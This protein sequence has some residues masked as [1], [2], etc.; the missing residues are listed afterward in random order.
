[1]KRFGIKHLLAL[2]F[3]LLVGVFFH[4]MVYR[5]SIPAKPFIYAAF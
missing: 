5:L 1:M 2:L 4:Y 3:G